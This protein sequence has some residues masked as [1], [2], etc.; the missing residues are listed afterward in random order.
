MKQN[1]VKCV[2]QLKNM[3]TERE[4][5]AVYA[6]KRYENQKECITKSFLMDQ[7]ENQHVPHAEN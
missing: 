5:I 3:D 6:L 7:V 4:L 1:R 2:D